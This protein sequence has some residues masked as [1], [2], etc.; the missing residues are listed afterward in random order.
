M[1]EPNARRGAKRRHTS[2]PAIRAGAAAIILLA[3]GACGSATTASTP[4]QGSAAGS[5]G[6]SGGAVTLSGSG[7]TFDAPFFDV[8][9]TR[10]H[11]Q[12]L[13]P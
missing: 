12:H 11:Q 2:H 10:H 7:S 8:A 1:S 4:G 5:P 13:I 3:L 9:F 6:T